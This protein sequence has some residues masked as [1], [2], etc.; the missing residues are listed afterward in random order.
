MNSKLIYLL[1]SISLTLLKAQV[2]NPLEFFPH[3]EGDMW[4]YFWNDLQYPDT[5]Q[6][7]NIHDSVD[8]EGNIYIT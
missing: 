7:F 4:E 6:N 3:K 8:A 5:V 2:P 1:F